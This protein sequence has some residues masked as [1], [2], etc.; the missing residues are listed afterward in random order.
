MR[1]L[2]QKRTKQVQ[3][4]V[5]LNYVTEQAFL[6]TVP[7]Y[8]KFTKI[9]SIDGNLSN[10]ETE[11]VKEVQ[12]IKKSKPLSKICR[13][14]YILYLPS[15]TIYFKP[16]VTAK[17]YKSHLETFKAAIFGLKHL[18]FPIFSSP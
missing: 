11:Y 3:Y 1:F 13:L 15:F 9:Q 10:S 7:A 4:S 12:A 5:I 17:Q 2:C 14:N 6:V 8:N 16:T 18:E